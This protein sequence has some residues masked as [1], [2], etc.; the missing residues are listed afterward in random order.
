MSSIVS[1]IDNALS[2]DSDHRM[3]VNIVYEAE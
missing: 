2:S 1:V 3:V